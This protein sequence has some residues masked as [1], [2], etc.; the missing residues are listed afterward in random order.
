VCARVDLLGP[1]V[2]ETVDDVWT[3]HPLFASLLVL[4][5]CGL[6]VHQQGAALFRH[7]SDLRTTLVMRA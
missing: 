3:A 7:A 5:A 1:A 6:I 2:R 4:L